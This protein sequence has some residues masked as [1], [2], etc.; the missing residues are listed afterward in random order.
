MAYKTPDEVAEEYLTYLKTLKPEVNTKQTDSDWWVRSRVVGG[1]VSGVYADQAKIADDAFPQS[2]RREAVGRWLETYFGTGFNAAQVSTG[3][4]A[5]FGE[6]GSTIPALTELVFEENGNSYQTT[7]VVVLS[8]TAQLIP[9][10]S[11]DAGQDQ[12]LLSGAVLT[13]SAP[14]AGIES[15]ASASGDFAGGSDEETTE[16]GAAR[17]LARMRDPISGGTQTDYE[18]WAFEG[19]DSVSSATVKRYAFGLGTVGIYI[20]AGTTDISA[21]VDAGTPVV[22][23]PSEQVIEDV[24]DYIE[25]VNPLTDCA[26]VLPPSE[27]PQDVTARVRFIPGITGSS[28]ISGTNGKTALELVE[29]QIKKALYSFPVGG[30]VLGASGFVVASEI[31]ESI[32]QALSNSPW[33]EGNVASIIIDRQIDDLSATGIN[34]LLAQNEIVEPGT[35]TVIVL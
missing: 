6:I 22:R 33:T 30:R 9:V 27:V 10:Q 5:M 16:Q 14:P 7:E 26:T 23:V 25:S 19:S 12:N 3:Y 15:T 18:Q 24:Q 20:T 13:V 8:A 34:R 29:N 11:I 2:A 17:V 4:A 32:D 1:V 31:E 35:I 28:I 21:A